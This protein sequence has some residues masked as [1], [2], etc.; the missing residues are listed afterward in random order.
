MRHL[1]IRNMGP[2]KEADIELK[3]F[4]ILIGAQ[5]SGKSTIAIGAYGK[6]YV[7]AEGRGK[8]DDE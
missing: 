7:R 2:I 8:K 5:S 6:W 4:N 1:I 3:R